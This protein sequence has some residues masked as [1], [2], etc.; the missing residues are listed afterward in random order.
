VLGSNTQISNVRLAA[1]KMMKVLWES[2]II[3]SHPSS[4]QPIGPNRRDKGTSWPNRRLA[5]KGRWEAW[6]LKETTVSP[7][8]THQH[9][10]DSSNIG[11]CNAITAGTA[12]YGV[13]RHVGLAPER[14]AV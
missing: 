14:W 3:V 8:H 7:P 12:E 2:Y 10:T 9:R 11:K 5:K 13:R 1:Y 6:L 4:H